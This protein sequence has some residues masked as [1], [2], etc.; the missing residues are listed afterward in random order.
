MHQQFFLPGSTEAGT[1]I[2]AKII[3]VEKSYVLVEYGNRYV[4]IARGEISTQA[5][6][7]APHFRDIMVSESVAL[8]L[9]E[10]SHG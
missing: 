7:P 4:W 8:E 6:Y 9:A 10:L 3:F 1:L 2:Y 5:L